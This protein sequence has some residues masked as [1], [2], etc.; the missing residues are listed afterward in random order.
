MKEEA[1]RKGTSGFDDKLTGLMNENGVRSHVNRYLE[2][3]DP[4]LPCALLLVNIDD[5]SEVNASRGRRAGD[6]ELCRIGKLLSHSFRA[7]DIIGRTGADEFV[8]FISGAVTEETLEE[9]AQSV[10]NR[11]R[12]SSEENGG[13]RLTASIGVC[14]AA[15]A[16]TYDELCAKARK[17]LKRAKEAGKDRACIENLGGGA[18][19]GNTALHESTP[20][21]SLGIV[22][23]LERMEEGVSLLEV[24][25]DGEI[26]IIYASRSFWRMREKGESAPLPADLMGVGLH[27]DDALCYAQ[28]LREHVESGKNLSHT[29]RIRGSGG[30]RWIEGRVSRIAWARRKQP[31]FLELSLDV[32]EMRRS[33]LWLEEMGQFLQ[34][35]VEKAPCVLWEVDVTTETYRLFDCRK[36]WR[37]QDRAWAKFPDEM[38]Q[39]AV[40]APDSAANFSRFARALL[41]GAAQGGGN[42]I[43]RNRTSGSYGWHSVSYRMIYDEEGNPLRALGISEGNSN[44]SAGQ[45]QRMEQ[46]FLPDILRYSLAGRL[47]VDLTKD[48][49][50]EV[51]TEGNELTGTTGGQTYSQ[52]LKSGR[53]LQF[54]EDSGEEVL[55]EF[56]RDR[57]LAEFEK[58]NRWSTIEFRRVDRSG[59][60]RWSSAV[61]ALGQDPETR[62]IV[63]LVF[64]RDINHKHGWELDLGR[65]VVRDRITGLY[66]RATLFA[67]AEHLIADRRRGFCAVA[68]IWIGGLGESVWAG[69]PE[70]R[71]RNRRYVGVALSLTLGSDVL[72]GLYEE[73]DT[74]IAFFPD[75]ES[76]QNVKKRLEEAFYY[77]RVLMQ[78][79]PAIESLRF[80][81][82]VACRRPERADLPLLEAAARYLCESGHSA[83]L[84]TVFT[85][86]DETWEWD[87]FQ[88]AEKNS[89][90]T[91]GSQEMSRD[92]SGEEKSVAFNCMAAMLTSNSLDDS[93]GSVLRQIGIYYRASRVYILALSESGQ[94]ITML[95]EWVSAGHPS[96]Q[97]VMTDVPIKQYPMFVRCLNEKAPV[98]LTI[99][100]RSGNEDEWHYT[101]CPL[102][103]EAGMEGFLCIENSREHPADAALLGT[104]IPYLLQERKRFQVVAG[105]VDA[106]GRDGLTGMANLRTYLDVLNTIDSDYYSSL[107]VLTVDIPHLSYVNSTLG[108]DYGREMLIYTAETISKIFRRALT[109]RTWDAEFVVLC[110]NVTR[111]VFSGQCTRLQVVLQRRY[112]NKLRFGSTWSNK[113]FTGRALVREASSLMRGGE[114]HPEEERQS[115]LD[116]YQ[117]GEEKKKMQ[118]RFTVYFQ[119]KIEMESGGLVGA[120]ALVRGL[121]AQGGVIPPAQFIEGMEKSGEIR[122]LD[123]FVM[124]RA[125]SYLERWREEGHELVPV[126]INFSRTTLLNP[127]SPAA[128]L[129]LKSHYPQL[130]EELLMIEITETAGDVGEE[131]LSDA[132]NRFRQFGFRFALDDFGSRYANLSIFSNVKF[133]EIKLD[134]SLIRDLPGN[135]ISRTLVQDIARICRDEG[136]RCVAEGVETEKQRQILIEAGCRCAQGYYYD[137]PMPAAMFE[138][139]YLDPRDGEQETG[140]MSCD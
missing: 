34:M 7:N 12:A 48:S 101:V 18:P 61:V 40:V 120:E 35:A 127:T 133:N 37:E 38:L 95:H 100:G 85:A 125:L 135:P 15:V 140:G 105:R 43:M 89:G 77:I 9:K 92:L 46:R 82:G 62:D 24:A 4:Q 50:E 23:I 96:I 45:M 130:S 131:T 83:A 72:L 76:E 25:E 86:G 47:R 94:T 99:P 59:E 14:V 53:L 68:V 129:A 30:W 71:Q 113:I 22:P 136:M 49:V 42:F 13:F 73:E 102:I 110:T 108:Y 51:W 60:I 26:R 10:R 88:Q 78:E 8:I 64:L 79:I 139:K 111:E 57:L 114:L 116:R 128:A 6:Q 75:A 44:L 31:V 55:E 81:A 11:L 17:A 122:E 36:S 80:V 63:M 33:N 91:V 70:N 87:A 118:G 138:S 54:P 112:P 115:L 107:G 20:L 56:A 19:E 3:M 134:R 2:H 137:R 106:A 117:D 27:P 121:D 98:I 126:S 123:L 74:L 103:G 119:P 66:D 5:F 29:Y 1:I 124:E 21:D 90:M 41:S 109:F 16:V 104:L 84:D 28:L 97:K 69:K 93:M 39:S 32:T 65:P 67:L 58:E 132:M 52:L